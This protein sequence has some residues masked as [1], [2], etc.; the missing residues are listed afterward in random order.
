LFISHD[1]AV[2]KQLADHIIVLKQG[3]IIESARTAAL[4]KAPATDYTRALL[5]AIPGNQLREL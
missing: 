2:V 4:F 1:M 3:K 5:S